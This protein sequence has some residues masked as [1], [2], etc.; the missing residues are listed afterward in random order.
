M[1]RLPLLLSPLSSFRSSLRLRPGAGT[2]F[3]IASASFGSSTP[4]DVQ[5][6][7]F[8]PYM[9]DQKEVFYTTDL[10]Y[11]FVNLRPTPHVLVCPRREV[12]RVVDLTTEET[13]DLW[14]SAQK[15]G[16]QLESYHK[17][18]SLTFTIQDGP[19]AGQTVPHV[20][21][22]IVP[23]KGGDFENNDEIYDAI[24]EKEKELKKTLD[25]DKE[26]TDRSMEER[27]QEAEKQKSGMELRTVGFISVHRRPTPESV[28]INDLRLLRVVLVYGVV[29]ECGSW[30]KVVVMGRIRVQIK[31]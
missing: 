10:A 27:A 26:R 17:A 6:Y 15:I 11:A 16:K 20:H 29:A 13:S 8:G 31:S 25:L 28:I 7:K 23:R 21:I 1:E 30:K 18:S 14:I 19:Q 22:H 4:M 24:D 2:R 9:I 5:Y 12:K 3:Q